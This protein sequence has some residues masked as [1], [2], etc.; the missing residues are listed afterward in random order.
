MKE[1]AH[2]PQFPDLLLPAETRA[3]DFPWHADYAEERS[4]GDL[5]PAL[6][7]FRF[8]QGRI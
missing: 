5:Y 4:R 7:L 1:N 3:S 6:L 8:K 2:G